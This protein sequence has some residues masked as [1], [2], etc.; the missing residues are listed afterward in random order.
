MFNIQDKSSMA[1]QTCLQ[2]AMLAAAVAFESSDNA[3]SNLLL[4]RRHSGFQRKVQWKIYSVTPAAMTRVSETGS[5]VICNGGAPRGATPSRRSTLRLR[6]VSI[7]IFSFTSQNVTLERGHLIYT[8]T[9]G[10]TSAMNP[11]DI[12]EIEIDGIGIL[13]NRGTG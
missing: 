6:S 10:T 13:K 12:V 2:P 4:E 7:G 3:D 11:G 1:D 9:P 5:A 8:G